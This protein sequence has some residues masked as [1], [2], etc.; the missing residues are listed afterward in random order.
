MAE[1]LKPQHLNA[2]KDDIA[3][4]HGRGRYFFITGSDERAKTISQHF[5]AL[6]VNQHP[7]QH[8]LYLGT[9]NSAAGAID[10]G[11]VSTGMG[12]SSADII[13]NELI[14]LGVKRLLRIGTAAS[15]Q[16][17]VQ[18]GDIVIATAAVRDD[19]AS[20]DYIHPEYP[21]IASLPYLIAIGRELAKNNTINGHFGI[22]HSKSSLYARE[23]DFSL[24]PENKEYMDSMEAAGIVATEM[25]CA[26]LFT[27]SSL[28]STVH[29]PIL[30]GAI[31]AI[32][33]DKDLSFST[34]EKKI[35]QGTR[36]A[37]DLSLNATQELFAIDN[38]PET[39]FT[40]K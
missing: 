22:V 36:A 17:H 32:V 31:L 11:A 8:N 33:G 9:L 14:M 34:N 3:G 20:W 28:F 6:H 18:V 40:A 37:I 7:R 29:S 10:V 19:K 30:C 25:E 5:D 39:L 4:N 35:N 16:A 1:L 2:C 12:G 26:Q 38:H 23:F 15:L 21:A 13:I 24:M 27:L